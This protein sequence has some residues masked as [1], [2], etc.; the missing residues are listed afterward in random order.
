M[1]GTKF[2]NCVATAILVSVVVL[3]W[4]AEAAPPD[5]GYRQIV[6]RPNAYIATKIYRNY[7]K[8]GNT[9]CMAINR[10]TQRDIC[11]VYDVYPDFFFLRPVHSLFPGSIPHNSA[12]QMWWAP[13]TQRPVLQCK[14]VSAKYRPAGFGFQCF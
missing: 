8:S 13:D 14:L 2:Q 11:V 9:V 10:N 12:L 3:S 4:S 1:W 6:E 5:Y 7:L